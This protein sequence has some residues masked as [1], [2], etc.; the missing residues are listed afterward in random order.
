MSPR[1]GE[2]VVIGRNAS[3]VPLHV[4]DDDERAAL[5]A[6]ALS[7]GLPFSNRHAASAAVREGSSHAS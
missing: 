4:L 7:P 1:P 6:L 2:D 5:R 3:R